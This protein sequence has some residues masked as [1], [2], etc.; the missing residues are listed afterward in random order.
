MPISS[1][2]HWNPTML[3]HQATALPVSSDNYF[4]M[5]DL[6]TNSYQALEIV[7][8]SIV[9]D[10]LFLHGVD[11]HREAGSEQ[12]TLYA[13]S[14]RPPQDRENAAFTGADS[15]VEIFETRVGSKEL[16]WVQTVEHEL[17]RTPNS[18]AA[19]GPRS[20]YI[21][22]DHRRKVHWVSYLTGATQ[23]QQPSL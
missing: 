22:N 8:P 9:T 3:N 17:V 16:R 5:L 23:P 19:T 20:F 12:L 15:V 2:I 1:R 14:H 10:N 13:I 11:I 6:T 7:A 4:A 18:V 21:T